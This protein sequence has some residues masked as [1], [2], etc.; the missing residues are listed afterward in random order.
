MACLKLPGWKWLLLGSLLA[1][2]LVGAACGDD[3][4]PAP[5][6]PSGITAADV[7]SAVKSAVGE[8]VGDTVSA[9]EIA[10]MVNEAVTG[11]DIPEGVSAEDV[12]MLV[13][14]AVKG[15]E[16]PE[17]VSAEEIDRMVKEATEGAIAGAE[18][19][20]TSEELAM[21]IDKAVS[22]AVAQATDI[23][24][25][26]IL[27][28]IATPVAM[29]EAA[30]VP[31][32][33]RRGKYG[34]TINFASTSD[35]GFI[36]LH[37]SASINS[38][39]TVAGNRFNQ[40]VEFNP[41]NASEVI[42]DLATTW[43]VSPDGRVY[44][45]TIHPDANWTDDARTPV[46]A[47]DAVF[48][49][50]RVVDPD[51]IRP[52]AGAALKPFYAPGNSRVIDE[53]TVE[54]TI[55]FPSA[56]FLPWLAFDYVKV[57]PKH[58]AENLSQDDINCCYE[59][60]V[61]SGP[62]MFKNLNRGSVIEWEK[63][64]NYFKEGRPFFDG[65]KGI[66]FKDRLRA[67]SSMQTGQIMGWTATY[68]NAPTFDVYEQLEKDTGGKVRAFQLPGAGA[69]GVML[70]WTKPPFDNEG[71]RK[72]V[73]MAIDR[74]EIIKSVF[75]GIGRQG[76]FLPG[77]SSVAEA[78]ANWPGWRYVD[79]DGNL[80]TTDPV[81]VVGS[82]KHPDDIAEAQRLVREAGYEDNFSGTVLSFDD[83]SSV[84]MSDLI[85][86]QLN[87]TFGWDLSV[88][89]LDLAAASIERNDG[90]F[91]LHQESHG[92]EL[93]D[94]NAL[95]GQMYLSGG[96][97]NSLNWHDPRIDDLAERQSRAGSTAE[98]KALVLE[99]ETI[100][101][102]EGIAQW[103]PLG[104]IP[105]NGALNVKIRNFHLPKASDVGAAWNVIHKK[106]HLWFNPDAQSDWGLGE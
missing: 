45:F 71:V 17:G 65:W 58:I 54:V 53:K 66:L 82:R 106:E 4:T 87:N 31:D 39:L 84:N 38:G 32:W 61:G 48:S 97:R 52:R 62:W 72:A 75:K 70:N 91:D 30:P 79:A 1:V 90:R 51:A 83:A 85:K 25:E 2:F 73:M 33:V 15:I 27:D 64:P 99:I 68:Q 59:N 96:G 47:A 55:K 41:V 105:V 80:I 10:G 40:L 95:L 28:R 24:V 88:K 34:G 8:A 104:W 29:A 78:E 22:D 49:L 76:T 74:V 63:N 98:R 19:G 3:A 37:F 93:N 44:T 6:Q 12:G 9:A 102:E 89:V 36:D 14:E 50:D 69:P 13:N 42:G 103:V 46:T 7:E 26:E 86:R 56:A 16:I 43:D 21:A 11:I 5:V 20:V 57:Y 81:Q 100:L 94:P 23:Q 101:R 92:V 35:P 67:I 60:M 77:G 18:A